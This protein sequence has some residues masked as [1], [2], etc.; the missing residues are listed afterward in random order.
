MALHWLSALVVDPPF[1]QKESDSSNEYGPKESEMPER[2]PTF[3]PPRTSN[4][5]PTLRQTVTQSSSADDYRSVI[6]D[7]TIEN[8]R[9]KEELRKYKRMGPDLLRKETLFEIKV[10]GLPQRKKRELE[11]TL[12]KFAAGLEGSTSNES[13]SQRKKGGKAPRFHSSS[14]T[15]SKH[16]SSAS[17]QSKPLDS[18]Y[19]SMSSWT[20]SNTH[21]ASSSGSLS[22]PSK[23]KSTSQDG[24]FL[25]P[26][27]PRGLYMGYKAMTEK[28]KKVL[29]VRRLEQ[30]FTGNTSSSQGRPGTSTSG[31]GLP[32]MVRGDDKTDLSREAH[33]APLTRGER[34]ARSRGNGS[35]SNSNG[36]A[37][38]SGGNGNGSGSGNGNGHSTGTNNSPPAAQ[39]PEQRP[40]R[41]LDLD[42]DRVQ[43][44]AENIQYI[45]HLGLE[46]PN[47]HEEFKME[48]VSPD[49]EGWVYLNL[50]C[51]LAQLHMLNVTPDFIRAAVSEKSTHF[52]LSRD[53]RKLRWRGGTQGTKFSSG[54]SGDTSNRSPSTD[55]MD[56]ANKGVPRK[57][58]KSGRTGSPISSRHGTKL[59]PQ[60]SKSSSLLHYKPI[61]FRRS[62]TEQTS[63]ETD[64]PNSFAQVEESNQEQSAWDISGSGSSLPRKRRVDGAII[65]YSGAPF[66]TDLSGDIGERS[67]SRYMQAAGQDMEEDNE[68]AR[69]SI[70][71]TDSGSSLKFRPLSDYSSILSEVMRID[72]SE[73]PEL[74]PDDSDVPSDLD[75]DKF[76]L[77][78]STGGQMLKPLPLDACGI[79]G[80]VPEDHFLVS[81]TTRRPINSVGSLGAAHPGYDESSKEKALESM[82]RRLSSGAPSAQP[83]SMGVGLWSNGSR[84][85]P[86]PIGVEYLSG[87]LKKLDPVRLPPP[88]RFLP[89]FSTDSEDMEETDDSAENSFPEVEVAG[90]GGIGMAHGPD[91]DMLIPLATVPRSDTAMKGVS[92]YDSSD[93]LTGDDVMRSAIAERH[94]APSRSSKGKGI[95]AP[96]PSAAVDAEDDEE[97]DDDTSMSP[98]LGVARVNSSTRSR[99]KRHVSTDQ[100]ATLGSSVATAGG[101]ESGYSSGAEES[102]P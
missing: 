100:A 25:P 10:H 45:R 71:R 93:D 65:Y 18:A 57:R 19:A 37:T 96:M 12:R 30:L 91:D 70:F 58:Q 88:A 23:A 85:D 28:E 102:P 92:E 1:F 51:N 38:E 15:Q 82:I 97:D 62:S 21:V 2:L 34:K 86:L 42:P 87:S 3:Y 48:D 74:V 84:S 54:D 95:A 20:R 98:P 53:G 75:E 73:A 63:D 8:K 78:W 99:S 44:P 72:P 52:Q 61:F 7:L 24:M 79:G 89:P 4:S 64:S 49:E 9:L 90:V 41:P 5:R 17:T 33:I 81:V 32:L 55:D 13:P 47:L 39:A 69:P 16:A 29:V 56:S 6:D 22:R 50:L 77:P 35:A 76:M 68:Y 31:P 60:T 40:T 66:C 94:G 59:G 101:M 80:V 67:P 11:E 14:G 36:D 83:A 46:P 26:E 43:I 27:V